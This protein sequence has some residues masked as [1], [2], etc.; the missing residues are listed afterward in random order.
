MRIR[1]EHAAGQR[2]QQCMTA[3][4]AE[5]DSLLK[6]LNAS[7]G[8]H[9]GVLHD[10]DGLATT[11]D[12][13]TVLAGLVSP[14]YDLDGNGGNL[15]VMQNGEAAGIDDEKMTVFSCDH[16]PTDRVSHFSLLGQ[17]GHA[18]YHNLQLRR[19]LHCH[20]NKLLQSFVGVRDGLQSVPQKW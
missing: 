7:L 17:Y 11:R 1:P 13:Q 20:G 16:Q 3:T 4:V 19:G 12:K 8:K 15:D 18:R 5:V 2:H 9:S 14:G 6:R 10:V